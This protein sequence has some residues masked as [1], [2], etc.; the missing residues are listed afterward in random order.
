M[1]KLNLPYVC[2]FYDSRGKLRHTFRRK[3]HRRVTIKGRPGDA[4]FMEHYHQLLAST[5]TALATI[6]TSRAPTGTVD[7]AVIAFLKHEDFIKGLSKATQ[8]TWR[9]ILSRF[10]EF[11]TPSGRRYGE[12]RIT[13]IT[14]AAIMAFLD[15]KTASTKKNTLKPI[16]GLIRFAIAQGLL[17]SDP[18][19][20]LKLR[21]PSKT[22]GHMTWLE[23]Q[24]AQFRERHALGTMARLAIELLLN[25]AARRHDAHLIGQ[26]HARDGKLT[27]R[28]HKTE[29][30]TGK[31]LTIKILPELRVAIDAIP[32]AA[33]ADGVMAFLVNDYG[34][35]FASAAVF[36]NKFAV[37]CK[38]AGLEPVVSADGRTRN[39]RAHGLRKAALRMLAHSGATASEMQAISGHTTM[40]Q[41]QEY[42]ADVEQER[43]ADA[44]LARLE[45]KTATASD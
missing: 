10:R 25:I 23:P 3:G 28:P 8:D 44:A 29:R 41:L 40:A 24:V 1:A 36:G 11:T 43:L 37:W 27:W 26:Q 9:P 12:N 35:P 4:E 5:G 20:G 32:K 2:T 33:R 18:I 15:G 45:I 17:T 19:E 30:S 39:Y 7:H 22:I 42:L 21:A 38:E 6:G 31:I 13:T 34:R 16:R 14:R